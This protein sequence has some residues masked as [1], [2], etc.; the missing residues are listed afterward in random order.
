MESDVQLELAFAV[1]KLVSK[2]SPGFIQKD[3]KRSRGNFAQSR[4]RAGYDSKTKVD[5]EV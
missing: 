5:L 1:R 4:W 3:F 2:I